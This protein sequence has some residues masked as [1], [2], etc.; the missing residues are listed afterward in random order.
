MS[1]L[2]ISERTHRELVE[3]LATVIRIADS[4]HYRDTA[5]MKPS[6]HP[7]F[8]WAREVLARAEGGVGRFRMIDGGGRL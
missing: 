4:G 5:Q 6:A 1:T 3:A 8:D 7:D 2:A